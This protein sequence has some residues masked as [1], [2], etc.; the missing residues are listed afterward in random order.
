MSVGT[1]LQDVSQGNPPPGVHSSRQ[2]PGSV[3]VEVIVCYLW[4]W[5]IRQRVSWC[6]RVSL[7]SLALN[8]QLPCCEQL[9]RGPWDKV[10]TSS[11]KPCNDLGSRS[12]QKIAKLADILT[13][14]SGEILSQ[15]RPVNSSQIPN[16][17]IGNNKCLSSYATKFSICYT[18]MHN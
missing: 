6:V 10:L 17:I 11:Q 9:W 12:L 7:K 16:L 15:N 14:T 8:S 4:N 18:A 1:N 3:C 2:A 13:S 5:A